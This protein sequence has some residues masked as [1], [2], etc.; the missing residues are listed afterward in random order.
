VAVVEALDVFCGAGGLSLGLE[1]AGVKVV[2]GVEV[3]PDAAATWALSH[4]GA[5]LTRG[6]AKKVPWR[7]F[8]GVDL[9]V[10][11]PPC[12]P[13]STGGLRLGHLDARDGWPAF[14]D[15][16][17]C[18]RPRAFLAE[19]V[20]GLA[21][22]A[23]KRRWWSLLGQ[24]AGLGYTV[25][26]KVLNAADFG[27]PQKRRRCIVVGMR[28]GY[29]FVFP[30]PGFGPGRPR[31]WRVAGSV[32]HAHPLGE[33]NRSPVRYA[34]RP[35]LRKD[36]YSGHL[37]NGGGRPI[38]LDRPSPTL[39][40]S[41]GGNKTPWV[42]TAGIVPSYHAHLLAGGSPR[43]GLVP[44]ARRITVE[45]AALLQGFPRW[46]CL[47]GRRSSQYRQVGNAVPPPLAEA[48]G[49]ALLEQL[50]S[51]AGLQMGGFAHRGA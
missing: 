27:V 49:R 22:G 21:E 29:H 50:G 15:A 36:P 11:G 26:A 25:S 39:L 42:D 40:A 51:P 45:E 13:W 18:L 1:A 46:V 20:A 5:E 47:V 12:Q 6:D 23:M 37:F 10:G 24:L 30:E 19:N 41:M 44:G 33:P 14:I 32:V 17:E 7:R 38:A 48:L 35:D 2:A 34:A 16:L 28:D 43:P 8:D 4:P 3:D 31:P 9:V